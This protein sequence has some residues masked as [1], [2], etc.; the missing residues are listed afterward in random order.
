LT[1]T[2]ATSSKDATTVLLPSLVEPIGIAFAS[3]FLSFLGVRTFQAGGLSVWWAEIPL[4]GLA[5]LLAVGA[6]RG[7]RNRRQLRLEV[8]QHSL[9]F[10][11][12]AVTRKEVVKVAYHKELLFKGVRIDLLDD[13]WMGIPHHLHKPKRVLA[14]LKSHGY[15]IEE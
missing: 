1:D 5:Y 4:F 10:A 12:E 2:T 11:N 3:V 14:T 15:P 6:I 8:D 7:F 9:S 13:K